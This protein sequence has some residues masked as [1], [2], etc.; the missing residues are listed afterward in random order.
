MNKT[1]T[2][3]IFL[4]CYLFSQVTVRAQEQREFSAEKIEEFK[5]EVKNLVSFLEY[6]FNT[7]GNPRTSARDKDVIINQS[8]AKIFL[9]AEVQVE[10][11][12]DD[13]RETLINK[14][15]QAY[16]KDIDFFFK[17]AVFALNISSI[18]HQFKADGEIFFIASLTRTL[19]ARTV[20][21]DSI[22]SNKERFIEVNYDDVAQ[23]LRIASIYTTRIDERDELFAWW[24]K[25]SLEWREILGSEATIKDTIPFSKVVEINDTIAIIEYYG[26]KEVPIDTF[27]VYD[28]DTLFIDEVDTIAGYIRDTVIPL[29][30]YNYRMLQRIASEPEIDISGNL[31]IMDLD[32]LAQMGN[33]TEVNC[34]NTLISDLSPLRSLIKIESLNCSGTPV[35]DLSPMQY[36]ISL[37]SLELN[38]TRTDNIDAL[39]NLRN[40]EKLN[41]SNTLIDSLEMLASLVHLSDLRIINTPVSEVNALQGLE[42]IRILNI[43]GTNV[44]DLSPLASLSQL[45]RL[46]ISNTEVDD[47][48]P[49]SGLDKLQTIYLDSTSVQSIEPLEGLPEL[50]HVYCDNT[51]VRGKAA[52]EF[53][54][55]NP[56][57][58]V[59]YESVALARWWEEMSQ[60]WKNIFMDIASL[61]PQPGKEQLHQAVKTEE[62]NISGNENITSLLP[63]KRLVQLKK[64]NCESTGISDLSPLSDLIDLKYLD[65]SNTGIQACDAL[66]DLMNLEYLNL[67]QTPIKEIQCLSRL[68]NLK[69]LNVEETGI[70]SVNVFEQTNLDLIRADNSQIGLFEV[71]QFKK[72]NPDCIVL[73]QTAELENWWSKL[74]TTWRNIFMKA[75]DIKTHPGPLEL[76][77]IADITAIDLEQS[78]TL[79]SLEPLKKLYRLKELRMNG[80]QMADLSPISD[81]QTI[82][83]LVISNNPV[84]SLQQVAGL[85]QLKHLELQN[86]PVDDLEPLT[87]L[88]H[89][90]ILDMAGTQIKKLDELQTLTNLKQLSVFNTSIKSLS[91]LESLSSLKSVKCYNTKLNERRVRKFQEARPDCEVIFY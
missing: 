35:T 83:V 13:N 42:K 78:I 68:K 17:E 50:E 11:D 6:S 34:A 70:S 41:L 55:K 16:L 47:L 85:N 87:G 3:L 21:G 86:T 38:S 74:N 33:I 15:V 44:H 89:L 62:V 8:F 5:A 67:S 46:Y 64:L 84:E 24:N 22:S 56:N 29:K 40:L 58:L 9:D 48:V 57:V 20:Q 1:S 60:E 51:G 63:L 26:T 30:N 76:Q 36:S 69:E 61:G 14:D 80:T 28:T 19:N 73:F 32:P 37:K 90:E 59:I 66:H 88:I 27:L 53:M 2:L 39:S 52:N 75:I 18:E 23:D 12:L 54:A 10:D 49:L 72:E 91:P 77:R 45:E 7:L 31:R 82:E 71:K 43:S 25:M 79:E 81:M 65:C 4:I